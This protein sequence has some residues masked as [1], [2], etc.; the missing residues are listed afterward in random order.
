MFLLSVSHGWFFFGTL[1]IILEMAGFYG[2]GLFL[3]GLSAL[4]VGVA[5]SFNLIAEHDFLLQFITL[6]TFTL[7]STAIFWKPLKRIR[8]ASSDVGVD[9]KG[10]VGVVVQGDLVRGKKGRVRWSGT[11]MLARCTEDVEHSIPEGSQVR[12][13]DVKGNQLLVQKI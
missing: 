6:F 5:L 8:S 11:T 10:Q 13:I 3:M 4:I 7:S 1:F 12:I 2:I 9:I